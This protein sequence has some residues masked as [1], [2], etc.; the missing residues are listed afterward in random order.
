MQ[1]RSLLIH[2]SQPDSLEAACKIWELVEDHSSPSVCLLVG[3]TTPATADQPSCHQKAL[4]W[5]VGR[6]FEL[7]EWERG[8]GGGYN[9]SEEGVVAL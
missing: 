9:D 2:F 3:T 1:F 8:P 5:C 4:E 7:V 6:G